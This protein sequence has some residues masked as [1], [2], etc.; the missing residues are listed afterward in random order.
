ML[1]GFIY[2][3]V[4][5][6]FICVKFVKLCVVKF[7]L[8]SCLCV[9]LFFRV[10]MLRVSIYISVF[11]WCVFCLRFVCVVCVF[12]DVVFKCVCVCVCEDC[13][14]VLCV[15]RF[16]RVFECDMCFWCVLCVFI[17]CVFIVCVFLSCVGNG[18]W[19]FCNCVVRVYVCLWLFELC[20]CGI[21]VC[22]VSACLCV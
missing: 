1:C 19:C 15:V 2:V 6:V 7:C 5:V 12:G 14:R 8:D 21:Y 9:S 16:V 11:A 17:V 13:V 22:C 3:F 20:V 4:C 18:L 10:D